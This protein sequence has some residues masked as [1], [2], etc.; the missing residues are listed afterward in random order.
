MLSAPIFFTRITFCNIFQWDFF[1]CDICNKYHIFGKNHSSK[2]KVTV[3][4]S[5]KKSDFT[6][7]RQLSYIFECPNTHTHTHRLYIH[8]QTH[9]LTNI[10]QLLQLS[11]VLQHVTDELVHLPPVEAGNFVVLKLFTPGDHL[12]YLGTWD[13]RDFMR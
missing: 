6:T 5:L 3:C 4:R 8:T 11:L 7:F 13:M 10:R 9:T 2:D 1:L 12:E